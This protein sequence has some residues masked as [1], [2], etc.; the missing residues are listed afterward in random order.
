[1]IVPVKPLLTLLA[2]FCTASF[3]RAQSDKDHM[4][5]DHMQHKPAEQPKPTVQPKPKPIVQPKPTVL[6]KP[7]EQPK[8]TDET[9]PAIQPKAPDKLSPGLKAMPMVQPPKRV[10]YRLDIKDTM[11]D[12]TGRRT[13]AIAIN[14]QIP[15]PTIEFTEGD[16]AVIDVHNSMQHS[17]SIHWHGILIPNLFDGVDGLTTFPIEHDSTLQI[18]F[19]IRQSGTYWYH[20]HTMTQEQIGLTGA[21][22]IHPRQP[23]THQ[24]QVLVLN[25]WTDTRPAEVWRQ[26]KRAG[27]WYPIKKHSVQSYGEA[28]RKGKFSDK[29]YQEWRRMPPMDISDVKYNEFHSNGKLSAG[30]H[31]AS[32]GKTVRLRVVNASATS[33]FW[34]QFAGGKITVVAA[35]GQEVEPVEVDKLLISTAETYDVMVSVPADGKWEFR[36]TAQDVS[37]YTSAWLG[38]GEAHAAPTIPRVDYFEILSHMNMMMKGMDMQMGASKGPTTNVEIRK[39]MD[40]SKMDMSEVDHSKMDMGGM[41]HGMMMGGMPMYGFTVPPGNGI[42]KVLSYM[43]LAAK[44]NDSIPVPTGMPDRCLP[45]KVGVAHR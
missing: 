44:N 40:H 41:G 31:L 26:L 19:V 18:K 8:P 17:T 39:T 9:K 29:I 35:D 45:L 32:N 11:V 28:L 34:L 43:M 37:G 30:L 22:V 27:E 33:Y 13:H 23:L 1:M 4:K 5:M 7:A 25:D 3:A 42:D 21:I 24:E 12:Y 10:Y 14:G 16:T 36:S 15:G 2:F 38:Q 6:P 20:S